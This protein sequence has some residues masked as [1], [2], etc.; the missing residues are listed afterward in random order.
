MPPKYGVDLTK[1]FSFR[2][3]PPTS[4]TTKRLKCAAA[5]EPLVEMT[6]QARLFS[7]IYKEKYHDRPRC[8]DYRRLDRH[9]PCHG[10]SLRPGRRPDSCLRPPRPGGTSPDPAA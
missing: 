7:N 8:P 10:A 5:P 4:P 3:E 2:P 1:S 6:C 9:W